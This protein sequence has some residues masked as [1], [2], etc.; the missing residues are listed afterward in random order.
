MVVRFAIASLLPVGAQAATD[1]VLSPDS[2]AA[3]FAQYGIVGAIA[4]GGIWFAWRANKRTEARADRYEEQL[5]QLHQENRD[6]VIP[7]MIAQ[8][9]TNAEVAQLLRDLLL[10]DRRAQ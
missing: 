5:S 8:T 3:S 2:Y 6:K 9:Q 1:A 7:A 4:F 10:R